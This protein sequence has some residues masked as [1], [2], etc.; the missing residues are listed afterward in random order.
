MHSF[1]LPQHLHIHQSRDTAFCC[2]CCLDMPAERI[3]LHDF[4]MKTEANK[5]MASDVETEE[6]VEI[7]Y[8]IHHKL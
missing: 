2:C 7:A 8:I 5:A 3:A 6:I 4:R 1:R